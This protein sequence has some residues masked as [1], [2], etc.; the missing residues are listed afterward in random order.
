M[1]KEKLIDI[2]IEELLVLRA[3]LA[4][5]QD[6]LSKLIGVSRQ[7]YSAIEAKKRRMTWNTFLSLILV[8]TLNEK[9]ALMLK[10][11]GVFPSELGSLFNVKE[12]ESVK[13]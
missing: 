6:E 5:S 12:I 13:T 8:L 9:T 3:R 7:T 1:D 2:L 11:S 10:T 4:L